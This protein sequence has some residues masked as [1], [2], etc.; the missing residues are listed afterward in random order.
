MTEYCYFQAKTTSQGK[1]EGTCAEKGFEKTTICY[2]VDFG[3]TA[4]HD[5]QTL[6]PTGKRR[7]HPIKLITKLE[8]SCVQWYA[9]FVSNEEI[10]EALI[11]FPVKDV[12]QGKVTYLTIKITSGHFISCVIRCPDILDPA[13]A[14]RPHVCE[15]ELMARK[16]EVTHLKYKEPGNIEHRGGVTAVDNWE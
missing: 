10:V 14:H 1:I 7:Y 11:Q 4:A 6:A 13:N 8:E 5:A 9:A 15:V 16:W 3:G 12:S 2:S